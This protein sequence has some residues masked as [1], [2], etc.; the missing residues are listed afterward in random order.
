MAH[1]KKTKQILI[2]A[3]AT[4]IVFATQI[5]I[6]FSEPKRPTETLNVDE[7]YQYHLL[8]S[9]PNDCVSADFSDDKKQSIV[10]F[11][12]ADLEAMAAQSKEGT[13]SPLANIHRAELALASI[14]DKKDALGCQTMSFKTDSDKFDLMYLVLDRVE[15]EKVAIYTNKT[16]QFEPTATVNYKSGPCCFGMID[17]ALPNDQI[18]FYLSWWVS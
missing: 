3:L 14:T 13:N 12:R 4:G 17:I 6:A 7:S 16:A 1:L 10:L 8:S 15:E 11:S 9:A 18:L 5:S 2:A